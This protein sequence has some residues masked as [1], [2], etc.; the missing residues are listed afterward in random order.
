[1]K[2]ES[3]TII[4]APRQIVWD[5]LNDETLLIECIP[6]C[7]AL[8][9]LADNQL[10]ASV[11]AKVGPVKAKFKGEVMLENVSP[12]H[13]YTL[14]GQGKGAAGFARGRAD[15]A[16]HDVEG[17]KTRLAW[18]VEANVGGKLAQ[19]GARLIDST[20]KKYAEDFF[21]CFSDLIVERMA[22]ETPSGPTAPT[23][24]QPIPAAEP[25]EDAQ[26]EPSA[27]PAPTPPT[28]DV[29]IGEDR[30]GLKPVLWVFALIAL[31][32]GLLYFLAR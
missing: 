9:R 23:T 19:M 29:P 18:S 17:D 11:T 1:M 25:I 14:V 20:A 10:A 32:L 3:E 22:K 28:H 24:E 8:E 31:V 13:A 12:P 16:L 27:A 26:T 6:G 30:P 4:P 2:L 5:A 21:T 15:V 7:E